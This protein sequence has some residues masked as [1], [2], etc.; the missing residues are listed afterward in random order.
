MNTKPVDYKKTLP[1]WSTTEK[2][3]DLEI[4]IGFQQS[5]KKKNC[6]FSKHS[7]EKMI[8]IKSIYFFKLW[9]KY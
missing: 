2:L 7:T 4:N 9:E 3:S 8:F 1:D 6:L 5:I